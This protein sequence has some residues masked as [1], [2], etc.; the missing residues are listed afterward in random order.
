MSHFLPW[1]MKGNVEKP[2][3]ALFHE[4]CVKKI[5]EGGG[6]TDLIVLTIKIVGE[7]E[8]DIVE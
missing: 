4:L 6:K 5:A 8:L 7:Y 2:N 3:T 1:R